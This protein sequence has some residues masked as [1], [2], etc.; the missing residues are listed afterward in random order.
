M[1]SEENVIEKTKRQCATKSIVTE[2]TS[3]DEECQ[4]SVNSSDDEWEI[5]LR[6][7]RELARKPT[8]VTLT[9][10]AKSIPTLL[11]ATSTTTKT[12]SRNELKLV[13]T[14][15]KAGGADLNDASLSVT[16]IKRQRRR[17]IEVEAGT[18]RDSFSS[19]K[20]FNDTFL[21]FH[22][23]GKII[24]LM[25]GKTED[26]L[27]I[28]VSSP[29]NLSGQ[30]IASPAISD[31]HGD[32]MAKCVFKVASDYQLI[33]SIQAL[34]FDTTASNTGKWRGSSTKFELMLG[35]PLLW[36]ACRHHVP[37]LFIKHANIAIRGETK[38]PDDPLFKEFKELVLWHQAYT[39]S[40]YAYFRTNLQ[41]TFRT[42]MIL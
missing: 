27:A 6:K 5:P 16:T 30:F 39:C 20:D 13:S 28:A 22:F 23:D 29:G 4:I 19:F 24:K 7:K 38:G 17:K 11:A 42:L 3:S 10:P 8:E 37:E 26:R 41:P 21:V 32:T 31:G 15:F 35:R 36:L 9:L 33:H 14:L 34:V 1:I 18:I 25:D 40:R 12:S 2:I